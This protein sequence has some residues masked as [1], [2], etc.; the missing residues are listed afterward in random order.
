MIIKSEVL[1]KLEVP[2]LIA[3]QWEKQ[4]GVDESIE[5]FMRDNLQDFI[6]EY[7]NKLAPK[8]IAMFL[9]DYVIGFVPASGG[10]YVDEEYTFQ[11]GINRY[12]ILAF[13]WTDE[14]SRP[15]INLL[16]YE[17]LCP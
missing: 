6:S 1:G 11:V 13:G 15:E 2:T 14:Y 4:R 7:K 16:G 17:E 9:R 3:E 12:T 10:H 8:D 5:S